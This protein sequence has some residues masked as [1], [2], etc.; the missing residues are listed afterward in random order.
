MI[1]RPPR[2]TL[3]PY[4]ALFRSR[5]SS[6]GTLSVNGS[7]SAVNVDLETGGMLTGTATL[8]VSG[9]LNWTGGT[10]GG[11][12]GEHICEIPTRLHIGSRRLLLKKII[13]NARVRTWC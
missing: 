1:R 11:R 7:A 12:A 8:S 2:S 10:I 3:F 6:S 4:T 5:V 13:N 9:T